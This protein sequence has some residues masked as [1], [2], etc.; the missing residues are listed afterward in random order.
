MPE[1]ATT[2]TEMISGAIAMAEVVVVAAAVASNS[3]TTEI[4]EVVVVAQDPVTVVSE[5]T[6]PQGAVGAH[7][8][9]S[10]AGVV[11]VDVATIL[12]AVGALTCASG[13]SSAAVVRVL[14]GRL[15]IAQVVHS[16]AQFCERGRTT[17]R[18]SSAM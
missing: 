8:G 15:V 10:K 9:A 6:L 14:C 5:V 2:A 1:L 18:N 7:K 17:I 16:R 11:G 4:V 12:L 3:V 13:G